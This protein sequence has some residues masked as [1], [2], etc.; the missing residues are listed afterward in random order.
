MGR[1]NPDPDTS[2][3]GTREGYTRR[4]GVLNV[5]T[6]AVATTRRMDH[7]AKA[8]STSKKVATEASKVLR[9]DQFSKTSK[10]VAGS[11]L[12]Q[13]KSPPKKK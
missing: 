6:R 4:T 3:A 1:A 11:D 2:C 12:S 8:K 5:R 7:M 10:S 13:K 9:D